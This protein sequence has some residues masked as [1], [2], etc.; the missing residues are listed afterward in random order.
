[1]KTVEQALATLLKSTNNNQII[2]IINIGEILGRVLAQDIKSTVNI[3]PYDNSAM[4]GFALKHTLGQGEFDISQRIP[5]GVAPKPLKKNT[6]ARIFT[7]AVIPENADCVVIQEECLIEGD[8]VDILAKMDKG[9]NIRKQG[10]D[11]KI[12]EIVLKKGQ[13]IRP[14]DMGLIASVGLNKIEVFS[15]ITIA[16]FSTG[17]EL[18]EP[19]NELSIGQIYNSNRYT[20]LGLL[21]NMPVNFLD[22]GIVPDDLQSTKDILQ[23]ASNEA[24][25]I[26]STGGV[27]VGEED[28]VKTALESLG[29]LTMYKVKMKPGKPFT[30]GKINKAYFL[31]L[32]GNPVSAFVIFNLFARSFIAKCIGLNYQLKIQKVV[33]DFDWHKKGMRREYARAKIINNKAEIYHSQSSGV[34]SSTVWAEG[35]V[36]IMEGTTVKKGDELDFI[37]FNQWQC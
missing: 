25:I 5:A 26:I 33:A 16:F 6:V 12:G 30:F 32:P 27:S 3:P 35:L 15:E 4:D 22:L 24:D 7:G 28:Y 11:V 10:E 31:G 18:I 9:Q 34:L 2:E 37:S 36:V 8:S 20:L 23:R 29:E 14:Q 21:K 1:M 19:G 13:I 17:N